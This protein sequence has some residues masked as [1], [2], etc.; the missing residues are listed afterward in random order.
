MKSFHFSKSFDMN[1]F[2][3]VTGKSSNNA[4]EL[5]GLHGYMQESKL[6]TVIWVICALE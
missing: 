2:D 1:D 6:T 5:N 3:E 4:A